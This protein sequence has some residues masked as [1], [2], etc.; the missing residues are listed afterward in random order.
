MR[1]LLSI[2]LVGTASYFVGSLYPPA[3]VTMAYPRP[4][5]PAP[6]RD[7]DE[8]RAY[9]AKVEKAITELPLVKKLA[10]SASRASKPDVAPSAAK[11][12]TSPATELPVYRNE[13]LAHYYISRPY[14][15]FP[16][17]KAQHS[18]TAG[19]LRG[20]GMIAVPPLVLS[21][22]AHGA[23]TLGGTKGDAFAFLHLGR[24]VCGHD[25]LIHGGLLATVLDET[26]ARTAFYSLPNKI[27][28]TAHLEIDYRKPVRAD[29]FVVVETR[30]VEAEGRKAWVQGTMKDLQGN[31]LVESKALFVEPRM[32][33][34]LNTSAVR[35]VMDQ[36]D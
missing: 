7:S 6:A 17:N 9:T 21:L 12:G 33:R 5:G 27:G 4:V 32:A 1:W 36:S 16:A 26:L 22:T 11:K 23:R 8:G 13:E 34:F 18:L 15:K 24:S 29:Q 10:A 35:A 2:G 28:V 19:S 20:P 3:M 31:T 25:G 14:A 30:L